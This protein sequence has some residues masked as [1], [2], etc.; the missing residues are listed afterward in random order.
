MISELVDWILGFILGIF[1]CLT[2]LCFLYG[3]LAMISPKYSTLNYNYIFTV[4][5]TG[6]LSG[7][8]AVLILAGFMLRR[9]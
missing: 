6:M 9:R 8:L 3:F 5:L 1:T 2:F 4:L 7:M